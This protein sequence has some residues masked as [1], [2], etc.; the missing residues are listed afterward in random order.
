MLLLFLTS[1]FLFFSQFLLCLVFI[2][3][4][5]FSNPDAGRIGAQIQMRG[6]IEASLD[7]FSDAVQE[8]R[9]QYEKNGAILWAPGCH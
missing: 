9:I 5:V 1:A 4:P 2:D 6:I 8:F 7:G 3:E